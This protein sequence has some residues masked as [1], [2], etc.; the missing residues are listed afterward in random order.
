MPVSAPLTVHRRC[1]DP[2]FSLCNEIAH[3]GIMVSGVDRTLTDP[4]DP[5]L[6]D[7]HDGP[8][9]PS[10]RWLHEPA[11]TTGTHPQENQ[12]VR[13]RRVIEALRTEG[14]DPSEIF[15][16][17]PFRTVADRLGSLAREIPGLRA[18]TID[19]QGA[20]WRGGCHV[21]GAR[22]RFA[23]ARCQGRVLG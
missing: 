11:T 14:V 13:L 7:A 22:R 10:S 19:P 12:I 1:D 18:G 9:I 23:C 6:F 20:R 2:M 8:R 4:A 16:L 17:A 5:D 15:A 21:P 3:K